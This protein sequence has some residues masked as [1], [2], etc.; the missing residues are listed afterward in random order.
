MLA[1][2]RDGRIQK[3]CWI[4]FV[5]TSGKKQECYWSNR[6]SLTVKDQ[7]IRFVTE[8][9]AGEKQLNAQWGRKVSSLARWTC[10]I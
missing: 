2:E 4:Y 9:R 6:L 5:P 1:G 7:L 3:N 8:R 10:D